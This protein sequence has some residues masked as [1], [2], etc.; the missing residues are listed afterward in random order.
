[1]TSRLN[2][3]AGAPAS[4]L[5]SFALRSRSA[6]PRV[7]IIEIHKLVFRPA[8]QGLRVNDIVGWTNLDIFR[9][10]A[11]ATDGSFDIDLPAGATDRTTS[12]LLKKSVFA[13]V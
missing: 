9:H 4:C 11:N 2:I 10:T 5:L 7:Y 3:M 1:M 12:R 8:P 6:E 13:A